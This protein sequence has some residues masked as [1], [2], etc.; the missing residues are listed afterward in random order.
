MFFFILI[1]KGYIHRIDM[2]VTWSVFQAAFP[3]QEEEQLDSWV[4]V[5]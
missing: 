5:G 2:G 1:C 4:H 3:L